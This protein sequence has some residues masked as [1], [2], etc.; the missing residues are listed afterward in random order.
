MDD[1]DW[2]NREHQNPDLPLS[3]IYMRVDWQTLR[4]LPKSRAMAFNFKTLFTP[5]TDFRNEP[6]IPKLLLKI[7][8]EGKKSIMEYKGTWHI[9]HKVIPALREWAKEQEDKGY[10]PKD[11]QERT[12][13]EDP[14][15]PGWEEHYPMHT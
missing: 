2:N 3:D 1:P 8:L 12:L 11:W 13:D 10:V 15:Y 7:L 4:R 14:F 9:V 6:F 5:V